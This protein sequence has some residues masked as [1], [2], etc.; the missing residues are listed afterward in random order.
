M[1]AITPC[2]AATINPAPTLAMTRSRVSVIRLLALAFGKRQQVAD[3]APERSPSRSRKN[4]ANNITNRLPSVAS[5]S[6]THAAGGRRNER[7]HALD[8]FVDERHRVFGQLHRHARR[9]PPAR[10]A[11]CDPAPT[12]TP[13]AGRS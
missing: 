13:L 9:A 4:I 8:T 2:A 10:C 6:A 12:P 11:R 3:L 5:I 1:P 7:E